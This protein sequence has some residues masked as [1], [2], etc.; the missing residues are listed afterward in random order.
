MC[1]HGRD[2]MATGADNG[3]LETGL[4]PHGKTARNSIYKNG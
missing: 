1:G 2:N 4:N 3:K